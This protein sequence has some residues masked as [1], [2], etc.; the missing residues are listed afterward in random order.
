MEELATQ[1]AAVRTRYPLRRIAVNGA[2]WE[3]IDTGHGPATL[4]LLPG[5]LGVAETSF[6][7]ILAFAAE[8]RVLSL[9]YPAAMAD[10]RLL[11]S[12]VAA[13]LASAGAGQAHVVGGSYSG[14]VAQYLAAWHPESVASLLLSNTGAPNV[15]RGRNYGFGAR[16]LTLLPERMV[17][18]QMQHRIH[19]FLPEA[20]PVQRFWR[21]YFM[22]LIPTF[23][24]QALVN[25]MRMQAQMDGAH[26]S[27]RLRAQPWQ[28]PALILDA[29]E[30]A[31]VSPHDRAALAGRMPQARA[32]TLPARSHVA[33]LE[34][35][36]TYISI[37][38]EFLC[39]L[40]PAA[41]GSTT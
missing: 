39:G 26:L 15:R 29:G 41:P 7:Y 34:D 20:T 9:S 24:K 1:L 4:L 37:Y 27:A 31:L 40:P 32:V 14:F 28:G 6:G 13:L 19:R 21:S 25:R 22:E 17:H 36:S 2:S 11:T 8:Y 5:A 12:G 16:M 18:A 3:Y 30:D 35:T 38:Q 10:V 33:S 23:R